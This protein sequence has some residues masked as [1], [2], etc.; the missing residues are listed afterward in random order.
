[1]VLILSNQ[2]KEKSQ[3]RRMLISD[4][5]LQKR[6]N[7]LPEIDGYGGNSSVDLH[8]TNQIV[9]IKLL[10]VLIKSFLLEFFLQ[11]LLNVL[12]KI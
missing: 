10:K 5:I 7:A 1:M 9:E 3:S 6:V 4:A 12:L 2:T 11:S 8:N